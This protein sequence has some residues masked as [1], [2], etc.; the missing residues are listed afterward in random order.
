VSSKLVVRSGFGIFFNGQDFHGT[1]GGNLLFAPPNVYSLSLTRV[2]L[3]GPPPV[4]LSQPIPANF[5]DTSSILASNISIQTRPVDRLTG[6]VYQWNTAIQ[7]ATSKSSNLELAYVGNTADDLDSAFNPNQVPWGQDGSVIANRRFQ[8]WRSFSALEYTGKSHYNALQ[9]KFEKRITTS[10]YNLTS[11]TYACGLADVAYFGSSG[12]GTQ[13]YDFS[14]AVP[15]PIFEPAFNEQ[16]SRQRLAV[17]NVWKLPLG[18][19]ARFGGQI[20]KAL[21]VLIG[22]WQTQFILTTRSGLPVNV[23]LPTTGV[24]PTTNKSFSFFSSQG[25]GQIRPNIVGDPN[26]GISPE[27]DRSAFLN[28][29]AFSLQPINTPGNAARNVAWGPSAFDVDGGITKRFSIGERNSFDFRL[30]LFNLM[31]HVNFGQ[32][33]STWGSANFGLITTAANGALGNP[34]QIQ[35]ALRFAF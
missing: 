8:Q 19:G 35:M 16:L 7:L 3:T 13:Y 21:N 12:G 5:L 24:D 28:L 1:S 33:A 25:G 11:Y 15:D 2:G 4:I 30:E 29:K 17:T 9:A 18:R 20:P 31:N 6:R 32:P 23:T 14:K 27:T 34:R 10:W 26:T 22:G